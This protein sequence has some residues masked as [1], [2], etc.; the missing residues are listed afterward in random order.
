MD[1]LQEI[2]KEHDEFRTLIKKIEDAK[3]SQKKELFEELYAKLIGHHESE[4]HVL[5][6]DVKRKS[7]EKGKDVVMEMIEEHSLAAY[8]FSVIQKTAIDNETWDAK[9]SVLKEVLTHHMD[10]EESELFKQAK[11]V[12][13]KEE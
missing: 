11:K 7:D 10:E 9:F 13:D 5:F 12:L 3:G 8:Q 2:K 1:V 4:E 6:T